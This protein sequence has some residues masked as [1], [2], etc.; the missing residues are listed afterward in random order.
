[1]TLDRQIRMLKIHE[2]PAILKKE[3]NNADKLLD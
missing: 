2:A 3:R 1:M